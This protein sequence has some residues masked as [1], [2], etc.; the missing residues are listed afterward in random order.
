MA[1]RT[2]ELLGVDPLERVLVV[3]ADDFGMSHGVNRAVVEAFD[4]GVVTSCSLLTVCPGTDEALALLAE[5]PD[6]PFGVHLTLVSESSTRRWPAAAPE[7]WSLHDGDGLLLAQTQREELLTRVSIEEVEGEM[8][9]QHAV[10]LERGLQPTH[11]DWH[12]LADGGR[13][14]ITQLTIDL[15][16]EFGLAARL[17]MPAGRRAAMKRGLPVLDNDFLDSF[18][19]DLTKKDEEYRTR[20]RSLPP[21]PTEW[22]VHPGSDDAASRAEDANWQIRHS[23][24]VALTHPLL[25]A[26]I[27]AEGIRLTD[28]RTARRVWAHTSEQAEADSGSK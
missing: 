4:R 22:A 6:I 12:C 13:D 11:L 15:A 14:D 20:V 5:R 8:R 16:A 28:H 7:A 9:A 3:N 19:L 26:T 10:V 24:L 17:W 18:A 1:A 23:D 27:E 25:R 21:G 2:V